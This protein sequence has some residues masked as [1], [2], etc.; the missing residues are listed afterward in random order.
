MRIAT[1]EYFAPDATIVVPEKVT[2]NLYLVLSGGCSIFP[3]QTPATSLETSEPSSAVKKTTGNLPSIY[4]SFE[5]KKHD[6]MNSQNIRIGEF[7]ILDLF[8]NTRLSEPGVVSPNVVKAKTNCLCLV[9]SGKDYVESMQEINRANAGEKK[10]FLKSCRV[11]RGLPDSDIQRLGDALIERSFATGTILE[12]EE[13]EH[14]SLSSSL[15]RGG[16]YLLRRGKCRVVK[17]VQGHVI[18]FG[19]IGVG[20]FVGQVKRGY[21]SLRQTKNGRRTLVANHQRVSVVASTHITTYVIPDFT[22]VC[23]A[24]EGLI[25]RLAEF[26]THVPYV[27]AQLSDKVDDDSQGFQTTTTTTERQILGMLKAQTKWDAYK[28][29]VIHHTISNRSLLLLREI[30]QPEKPR[31]RRQQQVFIRKRDNVVARVVLK[32]YPKCRAR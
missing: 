24:S 31:S 7:S 2:D 4:S 13:E 20:E 12:Q 27:H 26:K 6:V 18:D 11:F 30:K 14:E 1:A 3:P 29:D 23:Q 25:E 9:V 22:S 21:S 8:G 28:R 5:I 17:T 16:V 32:P 19:E 10:W 15:C